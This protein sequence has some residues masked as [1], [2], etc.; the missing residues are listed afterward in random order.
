[1]I[2][3]AEG[4]VYP[5][6][7][8]SMEW[9]AFEQSVAE[10]LRAKGFVAE[11]TRP[12]CDGGIDIVAQREE[13]LLRGKYLVQ[14]KNWVQPVGLSVV[15]DLYGTITAERASKGI[16][17]TTSSFTQGAIE[18]A[19]GKPLE[20]ID[21]E[22]WEELAKEIGGI[23]VGETATVSRAE[24]A[25]G[26]LSAFDDHAQWARRTMRELDDIYDRDRSVVTDQH[27]LTKEQR[28]K[29]CDGALDS[30]GSFRRSIR[31]VV[32]CGDLLKQVVNRWSDVKERGYGAS[33]QE[34]SNQLERCRHHIA[35][36]H[37]LFEQA[38]DVYSDLRRTLPPAE[39]RGLHGDA[40]EGMHYGLSAVLCLFTSTPAKEYEGKTVYMTLEAPQ[41]LVD[42]YAAKYH[43]LTDAAWE[44]LQSYRSRSW[45]RRLL[46]R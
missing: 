7:V 32:R 42:Y 28:T 43:E 40:L 12:A 30:V 36:Y 41:E 22:Q 14:C 9:A 46:G 20:L 38:F 27:V 24:I 45:L 13:P 11:V 19:N 33:P 4:R 31:E 3:P 5:T 16:L 10:V 8:V 18:F 15:R 44:G 34:E 17:I 23:H 2:A 29:Y 37:E 35:S 6:G 25:Q 39:F 1:V 26:V 21:G